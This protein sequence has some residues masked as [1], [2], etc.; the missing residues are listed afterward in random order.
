M[1]SHKI[2]IVGASIAGAGVVAALAISGGSLAF[3]ETPT[4]TPSASA[5]S[6]PSTSTSSS[7]SAA[8]TPTSSPTAGG[9]NGQS[10]DTPVTGDEA[11]QVGAA[12]TAKDSA[13]TVTSVRKDPDGSYDV[14]GTKA[15]SNV[16][17]DVSAD[18]ATITQNTRA[19]R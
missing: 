12:V 2:T 17:F 4:P 3:A 5:S 7:P 13:V 18:L 14:L 19:G 10:A 9:R 16:M 6:T 11:T 1:N 15:G 8:A